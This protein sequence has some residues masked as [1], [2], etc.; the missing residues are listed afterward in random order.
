VEVFNSLSESARQEI[1]SQ[2]ARAMLT[3]MGF[4]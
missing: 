3:R 4:A 1:V 2:C